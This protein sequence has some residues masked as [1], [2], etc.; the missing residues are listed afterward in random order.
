MS[1]KFSNKRRSNSRKTA[2]TYRKIFK[3]KRTQKMRGGTPLNNL[4]TAI[5]SYNINKV[6]KILTGKN[7]T[8][9]GKPPDINGIEYDMTPLFKALTKNPFN[10]GVVTEADEENYKI[11]KQII[12]LF[13]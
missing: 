2:R 5:D 4:M 13:N 6:K 1:S 12:R 8:M 7:K 11:I 10:N 9:F 3:N